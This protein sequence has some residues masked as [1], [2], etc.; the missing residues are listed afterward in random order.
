MES[1]V[2]RR[3]KQ[4]RFKLICGTVPLLLLLPVTYGIGKLALDLM[5]VAPGSTMWWITICLFG[6]GLLSYFVTGFF[7]GSLRLDGNAIS[8]ISRMDIA[9]KKVLSAFLEEVIKDESKP[10]GSNHRK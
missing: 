8:I 6:M 7:A 4:L 5:R 3:R 9:E 2:E 10:A 1:L